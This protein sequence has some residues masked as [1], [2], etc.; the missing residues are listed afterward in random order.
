MTTKEKVKA[1]WKL[2]FDD[3]DAFVD[4]YFDLRYRNNINICIESG[5]EVL[6]ALQAVPYPMTY[7]GKEIPTAYISGACTHPDHRGRGI[8]RH[9]L[10]ESFARMQR[11]G[12]LFSTL[13][14][15]EP[16]LFDYYAG[17]G[18]AP[19]F[20]YTERKIDLPEFIPSK[21][22]TVGQVTT[23]RH[24]VYEFLDRKMHERPC[25]LQHTADDFEVVLGDLRVSDGFL[26]V[27]RRGR[28]V[29]GVA[30][31]YVKEGWIAIDELLADDK[32][33]EYSLLHAIVQH[34]GCRHL[35]GRS[36][37]AVGT[38][39]SHLLGMARVIH[40]KEALQLYAAAFPDREL[41]IAVTDSQLAVNNGYYFV[42]KGRCMYSAERL[43]GT[44][45]YHQMS[46]GELSG[47]L[48]RQL[49]PYMSLMMD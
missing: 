25:C 29:D 40:V 23:F 42:Y 36:L 17:M 28:V 46:I 47:E 43:P 5:D 19:V 49:S 27:S 21:A 8:M 10:G 1:L 34:T 35:V 6:A 24:N 14:P 32:D 20:G 3:T 13:V 18:Y 30:I 26:F 2:C 22:I 4:M 15:A 9:L 37:P 48:F 31:G 44:G 7:C 45:T 38:A 16:W 39:P 11:D 12:I 41:Q 33:A